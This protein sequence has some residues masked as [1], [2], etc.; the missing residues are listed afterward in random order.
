MDPVERS[1]PPRPASVQVNRD[2]D[3]VVVVLDGE[4]DLASASILEEALEGILADRPKAVIIL[5]MAGVGFIDSS[6]LK[7]LLRANAGGASLRLRQPSLTVQTVV[8]ATGLDQVLPVD[9]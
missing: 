4:F 3:P 2:V 5:D 8:S 7:P 1:E 6:G 9:P